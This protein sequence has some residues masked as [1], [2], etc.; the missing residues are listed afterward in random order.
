MLSYRHAFHAGN[1]ADVLKHVALVQILLHLNRKQTPWWYVDTHA[2]AGLY[3]LGSDY[4]RKNAEYATGIGRLWRC[5]D[6]PPP[7]VADYLALVRA[8]NPQGRLTHYPGSPWLASR[9]MRPQD[10]LRLF[11]L[12]PTD[13]AQ[14]AAVFAHRARHVRIERSDGFTGLKAVLPPPARR[15]LVLIDPA[16]EVKA[17]YR[18]VLEALAAGLTRFAHGVYLLWY[19]LLVRQDARELA[20][21]L[22]RLAPDWLDAR[23]TVR[24]APDG[25]HGL[26]GS[27]VF[28][29]NPPWTLAEALRAS[30][31]WLARVLAQDAAASHTLEV[32][33]P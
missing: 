32:H 10:R 6:P 18:R 19:P 5:E 2:G 11:E 8:L 30:L 21:R 9:L 12:H 23:L 29:I 4:A 17:D 16:Y 33:S 31:P 15:G 22:R 27:G 7:A 28:V 24:A 26:Y 25:G 13:A 20:S 3:D 1:H 14:L